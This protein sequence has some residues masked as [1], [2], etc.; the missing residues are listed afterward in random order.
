MKGEMY[1]G[2]KKSQVTNYKSKHK[3]VKLPK[4]AKKMGPLCQKHKSEK[5][6]RRKKNPHEI[7][8]CYT[9][10]NKE[11]MILFSNFW[12]NLDL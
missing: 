4:S 7:I 11:R 1:L 5:I 8:K 6:T 3:Y 9:F 10:N 12:K 2:V